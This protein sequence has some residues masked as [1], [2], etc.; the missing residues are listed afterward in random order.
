MQH[1]IALDF[2]LE[3]D[4]QLCRLCIALVEEHPAS[5]AS[6]AKVTDHGGTLCMC[7]GEDVATGSHT[8]RYDKLV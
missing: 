8:V 5:A 7:V 2:R 3:T 6:C 1:S 4:I